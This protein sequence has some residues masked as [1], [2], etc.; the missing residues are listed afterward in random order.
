MSLLDSLRRGWWSGWAEFPELV[1]GGAG[2][3]ESLIPGDRPDDPL[4]RLQE[5]GKESARGLR[6]EGGEEEPEGLLGKIAQGIGAAPGTLASMAPFFLTTPASMTATTAGAIARPAIAFGT[7]SL[8]RHGAEGLPTAIGH[9]L[10][11]A[12]EGALFGGVGLKTGKMLVPG[13]AK[14]LLPKVQFLR[15]LKEHPA[16]ARLLERYEKQ[17]AE[18]GIDTLSRRLGRKAAH[19][20]G[21]GGVVGG[22]T[23]AHGGD[24]E[25]AVA[26]GATMGLLGM[27]SSGRYREPSMTP[28]QRLGAAEYLIKKE[29]GKRG[30]PEIKLP[31]EG[32]WVP[33]EGPPPTFAE[34]ARAGLKYDEPP[35]TRASI[36]QFKSLDPR[37]QRTVLE[38]QNQELP[39]SLE[40]YRRVAVTPEETYRLQANMAEINRQKANAAMMKEQAK[41]LK[42][43]ELARRAAEIEDQLAMA[44]VAETAGFE[45][46]S[47]SA[48]TAG[49]VLVNVKLGRLNEP[50]WVK[51]VRQFERVFG[52]DRSSRFVKLAQLSEGRPDLLKTLFD[53]ANTPTTWDYMMEYW[54]NGLLSGPS[55]QMVNTTSNALRQGI[56]HLEK[57]VGLWAEA[58]AGESKLTQA[59]RGAIMGADMKASWSGIRMFPKFIKAA[60]SEAETAKLI[61]EFPQYAKRTKLDHPTAA[62]PGKPGEIIRLPGRLLQ[63]MDMYFKGIAGER[64]AAYTAS[65]MAYEEFRAGKIGQ[66]EVEPRIRE[67][68]GERGNEP[69]REIL[70]A[71]QREAEIQTFTQ[72][73]RGTIG[74]AVSRAREVTTKIPILGI[75]VKPVQAIVPF[76]Q[77]PWNVISQSVARSPLGLLR[78]KGLKQRY[79]AGEI[80]STTYYKEASGTIMGT[81][82]WASLVGAA[83][84]GVITGSGPTNYADRQN[85]LQTG[86]RPYS[87]KLGDRYLQMQRL[88]PLGTILGM[89]GD[90]AEFGTTD[91]LTG[92]AVAMIKENMTNKSFLYGLESFAQA[93]ANPKQFGSTYYRQMSGSIIPTF[94]SKVAQAV[95][96]YQRV[97][98]PFGAEAGVPD[99]MA[100]RIPFVSRT[101]P[102]R[103]TAL[104]EKAERWGTLGEKGVLGRIVGG[105][106][107]M[108]SAMPVSGG[109][110][111]TE[112]ERE[113]ARLK[114]FP[115]IAPSPPRRDVRLRG[116]NAESIR[117][118]D[119]EYDI[120]NQ[121][122]Q[123]AKQHM[124]R[125][126]Q[127]YNYER[128]P[129]D[130]KAKIL[131]SVYDKYRRA[132]NDRITMLVRKRTTVGS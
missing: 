28:E 123:M 49:R 82:L 115:K 81:A 96:P 40:D 14:E 108:T 92:K 124:S 102:A 132:A 67:L 77:T 97:Q 112:V 38:R 70:E 36:E 114:G 8:V 72:P 117:L 90:A 106:Q 88:E 66:A 83:K 15:G 32:E 9:G 29:A 98:E 27:L 21:A 103:T 45:A 85:L 104:G 95:D 43:P 125:I 116:G 100:Y 12:A 13:S 79:K 120:Y 41:Q 129:D 94:F 57:R 50:D 119:E 47:G 99:A 18:T 30:L 24:L 73:V 118:T 109:R 37:S 51:S 76:W 131:R 87:I 128:L 122:H 26:G 105:I 4:E 91:D 6:L 65:K 78:M 59:D 46:A 61:E 35:R 44:E 22:M 11:G 68:M 34:T 86:W 89:A 25:E 16:A 130:A 93:F 63:V 56:D 5:W 2:L 62:I 107:S 3:L 42:D 58:K 17:L 111:D 126:I 39:Y 31:K 110:A 7:H 54:I 1:A 55:T 64:A 52:K 53:V 71:M 48:S 84:M 113:L 127:S 20:L 75:D 23:L 33:P 121:M 60:L 69:A 101:L 80:D 10:R 74:P 19:G